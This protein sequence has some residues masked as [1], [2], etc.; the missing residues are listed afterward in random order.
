[1]LRHRYARPDTALADFRALQR[2]VS[3][4]SEPN[5]ADEKKIGEIPKACPSL[6]MNY[7]RRTMLPTSEIH[8]Q[9]LADVT[10]ALALR[11]KRADYCQGGS[12]RSQ[13]QS[14]PCN[15]FGIK[16]LTSNPYALKILQTHFVEPA[17][18]KAFAEG[19]ERGDPKPKPIPKSKPSEKSRR[20]RK[21]KKYFQFQ[22]SKKILSF[23]AKSRNQPPNFCHSERKRGTCF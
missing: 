6:T 16:I 7:A 21:F 9:A 20:N 2:N 17:P 22:I 13:G 1:M 3:F 4:L 8:R 10:S 12:S 23:R 5:L 18:G 19:R 11:M 14:R 15:S